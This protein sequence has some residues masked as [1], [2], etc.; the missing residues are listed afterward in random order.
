MERT[1]SAI[2]TGAEALIVVFWDRK[3]EALG[4]IV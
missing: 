4:N 1:G 2:V 3:N